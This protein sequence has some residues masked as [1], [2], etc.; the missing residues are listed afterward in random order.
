MS[1]AA[2]FNGKL[3]SEALSVDP[4]DRGLL[5]GDGLFET[6]AVF[7]GKPIWLADHLDRLSHGALALALPCDRPRTEAAISEVLTAAQH[8][9]GI[10][11]VTLTRGAGVRGLAADGRSPSL[12]V[13]F[14][15][16]TAGT[17]F[18]PVKLVTSAIRRNETSPASRLK[19]LSYIDNILA[20][21]EAAAAGADDALFLNTRGHVASTTIANIF[22]LRGN[23]LSTPRLSDG[24]LSGIARAKLLAIAQAEER[25]ITLTELAA[26]DAVFLTN[27]L[28][29][30]RPVHALDGTTLRRA[31]TALD[32]FFDRICRLI[33]EESGSDPRPIDAL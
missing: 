10:L 11:R 17:F 28:R 24:V 25:K 31:D 33:A 12:L 27:S 9:H 19:T 16:W 6:I 3:F 15:P 2:W 14:A 32:G 7:N 23:R 5:L 26:A 20:A 21:R 4:S 22:I 13:T 30:I 8:R 1:T 29:L 18:T